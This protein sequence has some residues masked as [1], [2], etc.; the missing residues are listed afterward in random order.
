MAEWVKGQLTIALSVE[1]RVDRPNRYQ[2]MSLARILVVAL[3][4][5]KRNPAL[6]GVSFY[7]SI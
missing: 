1:V 7:L 3:S 4:E 6:S 2:L 5:I